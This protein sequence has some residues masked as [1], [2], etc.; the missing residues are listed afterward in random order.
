MVG[1]DLKKIFEIISCKIRQYLP[2]ENL[3]IYYTAKKTDYCF[4]GK[5]GRWMSC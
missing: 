2:D 3:A 1:A 5:I 4:L